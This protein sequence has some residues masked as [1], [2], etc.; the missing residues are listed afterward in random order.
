M[1]KTTGQ[2]MQMYNDFITLSMIEKEDYN[3]KIN[4]TCK[5]HAE[6]TR[7]IINSA[8]Q[9]K[10]K[11]QAETVGYQEDQE[12]H[13]AVIATIDGKNYY[14]DIN[15]DLYRVQKGLKTKG[16]ATL[17]FVWNGTKCE[18]VSAEELRRIDEK[19]GYCNG[20]YTDDIIEML[21][22]EMQQEQNWEQYNNGKPKESAFEYKIDF[23]FEHL[24]NN[25]L[26]Q[27]EM[28]IVEVN[29]Y[30][31]NL[32]Y[33]LL[34]E[35]ELKKNKLIDID[36]VIKNGDSS[37]KSLLYEIQMEDKNLYYIYSQQ[38]KTFVKTDEQEITKMQKNKTLKYESYKMPQ[39][40]EGD[41]R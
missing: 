23:I 40:S 12:S 19:L 21:R 25:I 14:L 10:R 35:E 18:V 32:Y 6:I 7:D 13:V 38:E 11:I 30:Y 1:Q 31:K 17:D 37:I 26:E 24:K 27:N 36:V 29:K 2:V 15:K 8:N 33:H 20:L 22:K 39:F 41:T 16:F 5:Q 9:I 3:N 28:G 4:A 34:T